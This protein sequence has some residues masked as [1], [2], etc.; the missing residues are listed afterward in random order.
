MAV[1]SQQKLELLK[2]RKLK[3]LIELELDFEGFPVTAILGPNGNGKSTVLHALAC[4][5][6]PVTSGDNLKFSNFFLPSTDALWNESYLEITHTY[7][8]GPTL[9]SSVKTIYEKTSRWK[10]I[11]ARQPKRDLFYIGIDKC[12]PMIEMEKKQAKINYATS[13]VAEDAFTIILQKASEI[14]NR[15]YLKYNIH[16]ASGK[17]FMGV[18]VEGLRY[19]ALSMSAGEQ[20][21]FHILKILYNAPKNSLILIDELDLLL[22]DKAMM[23]LINVIH[24]RSIEKSL[25]VVFTTHRETVI[26]LSDKLNIRHLLSTSTKTL[27]FNDTTP[28]AINRLT[29]VQH[30]PI[31]LFVEDDLS[32]AIVTKIAS[33]LCGKRLV[34][35]QR[36]GAASNSFT[37]VAG[38]L[39]SKQDISN[40]LFVLDGDVYKTQDQ[41]IQRLNKVITGTD[42]LSEKYKDQAISVIKQYEL[43]IGSK[44]EPYLHGIICN[45]G[46]SDNEEFQEIIDA[47]N[48]IIVADESHKYINEIIERLGLERKVGLSKIIDLVATTEAWNEY[49]SEIKAW[50]SDK[51]IPLLEHRENMA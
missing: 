26:S 5:Y 6:Q 16:T 10:P 49:T 40:T 44:P 51:I 21:I 50:I 27:C 37:A 14:L 41:K 46:Q 20:K 43:P 23:A 31:E 8:D 29:G 45:I 36:F 48:D 9:H 42:D 7:R 13:E 30:K 39:F 24:A 38:L 25:Q 19:S 28:D 22:H 34:S 17:K 4:A 1:I 47:A 18:E 32:S 11:Y 12:V 35:I 15:R 2:V 33:Q 3:N